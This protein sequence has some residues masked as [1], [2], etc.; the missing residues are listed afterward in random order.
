[1]LFPQVVEIVL[2]YLREKVVRLGRWLDVFLSPYY[3]WVI[4]R[5]GEAIKPDT[6][7]GEEAELPRYES[8]RGPGST[9]DVDFWTSRDVREIVKS[10]LNF[11]VA[12]TKVWEQAAA[13]VIDTHDK[14]ESFVKNPGLGF[15]IPYLHNGEPHDYVRTSSFVLRAHRPLISSS[16]QKD[17]TILPG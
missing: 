9:A 1:M 16:K 4:E 15:A 13:Y 6:A 10:H 14:V 7:H 11:V 8:S 5:L 12:D 3:G 17:L 2:R